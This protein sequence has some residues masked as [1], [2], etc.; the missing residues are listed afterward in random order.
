MMKGRVQ[1]VETLHLAVVTL[2]PTKKGCTTTR[3][4]MHLVEGDACTAALMAG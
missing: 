3:R 4:S 1:S 2:Q